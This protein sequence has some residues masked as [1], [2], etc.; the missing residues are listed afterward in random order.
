[1][2]AAKVF[3]LACALALASASVSA[4]TL[5]VASAS[6]VVGLDPHAVSDAVSVSFTSNIY[7]P[8]V[9]FDKRM[10]ISPVLATDWNRVSPTL[11]RFTLRGGVRFHD[12]TPLTADDVVFSFRRVNH[13][14]SFF[15][16]A[17]IAAVR[18]I[19]E[20]VVELETVM[21]LP[22]LLEEIAGVGIMSMRWCEDNLARMPAAGADASRNS[23]SFMANGT[24]PYRLMERRP[25]L[26]TVLV[27]NDR[28]WQKA[29]GN[30]D[31]VVYTPMPIDSARVAALLSRQIDFMEPVPPQYVDRI[32]ADPR[33]TVL[34]GPEA[35][36]IFLGMDQRRDELLYSSVKGKNPL[37]DPR[38][39]Q[40]LYQAIDVE[41]IK[42]RVMRGASRPTGLMVAAGVHGYQ[43]DMDVRL[44]HDRGASKRL[45]SEAGYR[46]G[47]ELDMNC[48]G[49]RYVNDEAICKAIT[50]QL[51]RVG[52]VVQLR[53]E[54]KALFLPRIRRRDTSFYLLGWAPGT[55]DAYNTLD[56][57]MSTPD[58][59]SGRGRANAGG[60][61][62]S[63]VDVL[64]TAIHA[65][66]DD[67]DRNR[68]IREAF[69]IHQG[70]I[71][72]IPLH[73]Q[74]L[75]WAFDKRLHVVQP[76]TNLLL[77]KWMSLN[78]P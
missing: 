46:E 76:P 67:G 48:P 13:P 73:D 71:G 23:A 54:P 11:W 78:A 72:H 39:R 14:Q 60:Y 40:A 6:D 77:F 9:G 50:A 24:G 12:G 52:V 58:E 1:M 55:L 61:S 42:T 56:A 29:E 70:D 53:I 66:L 35:R 75:A 19:D 69:G 28:H 43:S 26:R 4:V 64:T 36:T 3:L 63:R 41:A 33:F 62:N 30:I 49:D 18:K 15:R 8:L 37:K 68:M 16:N 27:R 31:E 59:A 74:M 20:S 45:L 17:S 5:R 47:F 7:E 38:V 44:P 65:E 51:A 21:P 34:Q 25:D 32:R 57:V 22:T 2:L 10:R